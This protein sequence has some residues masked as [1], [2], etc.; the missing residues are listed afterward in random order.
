MDEVSVYT[1][2]TNAWSIARR[3]EMRFRLTYEHGFLPSQNLWRDFLLNCEEIG[4]AL[5]SQTLAPAF[6]R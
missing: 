5:P 1:V 3:R 2:E 6:V 4:S